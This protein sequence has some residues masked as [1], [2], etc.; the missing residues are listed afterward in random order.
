MR[1]SHG[2]NLVELALLLPLLLVLLGLAFD[3]GRGVQAYLVVTHAAREAVQY[4][5]SNP[6][7]LE[8]ITAL[9]EEELQRGGLTP[10]AVTV[11]VSGAGTGNPIQVTVVYGFSLLF[12]VLDVPQ[13]MI[14]STAESV[15]L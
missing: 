11:S 4:A 10:T 5:A 3:I 1:R 8:G 14:Q 13:L 7:D 6:T 15:I 12:N 9:V 2:Q